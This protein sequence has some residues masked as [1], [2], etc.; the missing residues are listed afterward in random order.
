MSDAKL[1]AKISR[2]A[3]EELQV[4]V[5]EYKSKRY[6]DLRIFY[7]TDAGETWLPTKKG[8]TVSPD[9]L[10]EFQQAVAEA[11]NELLSAEE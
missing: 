8:V 7:T 6:L 9:S 11:A 1:I 5:K 4:A 10:E 2:S 3:T